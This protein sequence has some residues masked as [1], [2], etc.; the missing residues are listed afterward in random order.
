MIGLACVEDITVP[1]IALMVGASVSA[2]EKF[3]QRNRAEL[4]AA[5]NEMAVPEATYI[6]VMDLWA[7]QYSNAEI[8]QRTGLSATVVRRMILIAE[9]DE[10]PIDQ[11]AGLELLALH[12][13]HPGRRYEDY[14]AGLQ[15]AA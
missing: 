9:H 7:D 14:D 6:T 5:R 8:S 15:L 11:G 3:Y 10:A 13:A 2:V 1:E 12:A 4:Y